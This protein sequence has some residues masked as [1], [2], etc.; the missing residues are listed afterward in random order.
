MGCN[1][2]AGK[3]DFQGTLHDLSFDDKRQFVL[4][5]KFLSGGYAN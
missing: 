3:G 5:V 4:E 1:S 2:P